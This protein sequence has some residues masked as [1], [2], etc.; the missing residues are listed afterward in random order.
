MTPQDTLR[1]NA[2]SAS[3]AISIRASRVSWRNRRLRPIAAASA[4]APDGS[5]VPSVAVAAVF[6]ARAATSSAVAAVAAGLGRCPMMVISSRSITII[7]APSNHSSGSRLVNH[8]RI[9]SCGWAASSC[10]ADGM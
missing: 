9:C 6:A 3:R 7:G 4:S 2:C 8:P 1:R 10:F 5:A